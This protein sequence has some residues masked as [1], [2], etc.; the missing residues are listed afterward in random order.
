MTIEGSNQA[1]R[2]Y[3][4]KVSH[5]DVGMAEIANKNFGFML[6]GRLDS[7][8]DMVCAHAFGSTRLS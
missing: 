7:D 2:W 3:I 8:P 6:Y 4:A 1:F 5:S